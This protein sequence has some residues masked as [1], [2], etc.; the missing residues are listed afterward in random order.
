[1]AFK[2]SLIDYYFIVYYFVTSMFVT[3]VAKIMKNTQ[4]YLSYGP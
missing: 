3:S 1:M 2:F 4:L